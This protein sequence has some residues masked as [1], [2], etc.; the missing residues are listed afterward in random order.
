MEVRRQKG[1][2]LLELMLTISILS[3]MLILSVAYYQSVSSSQK[4]TQANAMIAD[5]YA[6]SKDYVKTP[7]A[8]KLGLIVLETSGLLSNYYTY[9]PWGGIF[10]VDPDGV[11][12]R[13][14]MT[15]VNEDDCIKLQS[16]IEQTLTSSNETSSNTQMCAQNVFTVYYDLY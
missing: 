8:N 10:K 3:V 11:G 6:A 16:R 13:I 4:I 15:N 2:G 7:D 5:I 14:S 1:I 12:V 9:N